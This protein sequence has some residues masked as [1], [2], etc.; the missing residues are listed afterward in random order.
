MGQQQQQEV[1]SEE[2]LWKKQRGR[3]TFTYT[4]TSGA[5]KAV[6]PEGFQA[7]LLPLLFLFLHL[8][9]APVLPSLPLPCPSPRCCPNG[10]APK[11]TMPL[12][13]PRTG[14][15]GGAERASRGS[16]PLLSSNRRERR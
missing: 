13:F 3:Q 12:S 5:P 16:S 6:C 11:G 4:G 2:E 1:T 9:Q 8:C 10:P 7:L 14:T 15:A